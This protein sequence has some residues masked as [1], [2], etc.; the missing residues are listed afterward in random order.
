MSV[1]HHIPNTIT[2]LNL[3]CGF[4]ALIMAFG[5]H[6]GSLIIACYL[7]GVA[8]VLDFLDGL[9]ART[10][11]MYSEFGKQLDSLADMV[12]FGLVPGVIMF[13]LINQATAGIDNILLPIVAVFIPICSAL[14]L[15]KFNIDTQQSDSFKG[16]P[17]P[18][19]AI[20][21]ASLP[22][23][24]A[25]D[26]YGLANW[27]SNPFVLIAFAITCSLLLVSNI[28][29]FSL[30]MKDLSWRNNK[31]IY[32]FLLLA[33]VL[34]ALLHFTALPIIILLYIIVSLITQNQ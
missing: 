28:S 16:L 8:T 7:V 2:S 29:M 5:E 17:T 18:A 3:A 26:E 22:L 6:E 12:T 10:L 11:G 23:V 33:L 24:L 14:R 4:L 19:N 32:S 31:L 34:I 30:K 1:K 13:Q 21:I 25:H 15:A 27:L 20:L 9:A